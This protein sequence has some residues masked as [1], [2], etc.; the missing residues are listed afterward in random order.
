MQKVGNAH[1]KRNPKHQHDLA[2]NISGNTGDIL[3]REAKHQAGP[4]GDTTQPK[5]EGRGDH[6]DQPDQ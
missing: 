6:C 2:R 5:Q 1:Q 4:K 3:Q